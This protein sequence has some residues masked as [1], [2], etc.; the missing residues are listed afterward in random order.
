[1]NFAIII[2]TCKPGYLHKN[3]QFRK[4]TQHVTLHEILAFDV[5]D[6]K[7]IV[8]C[9]EELNEGTFLSAVYKL[10]PRGF[11]RKSTRKNH[12]VQKSEINFCE[13]LHTDSLNL[14]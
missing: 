11:P 1:M 13:N 4:I 6:V 10:L 3:R 2:D 7:W 14:G 8:L 5:T 12:C 9:D